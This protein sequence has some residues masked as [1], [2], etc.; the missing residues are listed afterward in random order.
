M[1]NKV[2]GVT[3]RIELHGERADGLDPA[4][5]DGRGR[6]PR[7]SSLAN[8]SLGWRA[9]DRIVLASSDYNQDRS[10]EAVIASVS[11]STITLAAPLRYEHYGQVL[12]GERDVPVDERAEVGLLSRNITIQGDTGSTPGLRRPHHRHGRSHR[13]YRGRR[14]VPDG[15]AGPSGALSDALAHGGRRQRPVFPEQQRLA[16][17]Q[18]LCHG[19]RQP[20]TAAVQD[21]VCY[22]H[23]GHGYFLEDGAEIGNLIEG[24]L[25]LTS[26][27]PT[28][29]DRL[30]ASDCPPGHLLDHQP[31]Q[32]RSGQ[33]RGRLP[34]LRLLVRLPRVAH[35]AVRRA[36]RTCRGPRRCASSPATW[37]TPTTAAAS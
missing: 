7:P 2:L 29:A 14:A 28:G 19:P 9:G 13:A 15:A 37:P 34:G 22:D 24:N 1:G 17:L 18:P 23:T 5:P 11:G 35:R 21:N 16:D 27:V 20:T 31:G 33:R 6:V 12:H 26:R 32:H 36:S 25:G 10:E 30:L 8:G 4:R 3:G